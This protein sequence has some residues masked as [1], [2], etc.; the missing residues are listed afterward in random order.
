MSLQKHKLN[1]LHRCRYGNCIIRSGEKRTSK[2]FY[3]AEF[4]H[5]FEIDLSVDDV[6]I[7]PENICN[8]HKALLHRARQSLR[9]SY[10]YVPTTTPFEFVRH[11]DLGTK[12]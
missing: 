11:Q 8:K 5:V 9:K 4:K 6:T 3:A 1:L 2:H 7:H 12:L 10:T